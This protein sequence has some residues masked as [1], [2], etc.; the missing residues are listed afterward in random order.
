ML[1]KEHKLSFLRRVSSGDLTSSISDYD[2][3]FCA[4][5]LKFAKHVDL[6][7]SPWEKRR[8]LCEEMAILTSSIVVIISQC[9]SKHYI[10][11][12]NC[13]HFYLSIMPQ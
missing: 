9:V 5:Y 8:Q 4:V 11:P 10:V 12:L 2:A 6:R 7:C 3:Q 13:I 1:A